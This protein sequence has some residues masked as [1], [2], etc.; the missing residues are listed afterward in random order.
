MDQE[1]LPPDGEVIHSLINSMFTLC[2]GPSV[3]EQVYKDREY[4]AVVKIKTW[5]EPQ[6]LTHL[7]PL[8]ASEQ[9]PLNHHRHKSWKLLQEGNEG[10][11]IL[12]FPSYPSRTFPGVVSSAKV[13][14]NWLP[15]FSSCSTLQMKIRIKNC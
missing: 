13:R 5:K 11:F 2:H 7:T 8:E 3:S 12:K 1:E 15:P 9:R 6:T 14:K 4:S 10:F